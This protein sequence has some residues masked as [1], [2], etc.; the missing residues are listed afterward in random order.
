MLRLENIAKLFYQNQRKPICV[1]F[2]A[3]TFLI[4]EDYVCKVGILF[5][6][7][8]SIIGLSLFESESSLNERNAL[9]R[10]KAV[11]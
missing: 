3:P 7:F 9:L 2:F 10:P 5:L 6:E 4:A 11:N 8:A 1:E